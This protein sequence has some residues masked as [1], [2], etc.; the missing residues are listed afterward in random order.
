MF[1][2]ATTIPGQGSRA[3]CVL[4]RPRTAADRYFVRI[5]YGDGCSGTVRTSTLTQLEYLITGCIE[6]FVRSFRWATRREPTWL[7]HSPI[8][9][10]SLPASF[11]T[12]YCMYSVSSRTNNHRGKISPTTFRF[13]SWTITSRS[14][15]ICRGLSRKHPIRQGKCKFE[16]KYRDGH[17]LPLGRQLRQIHLGQRSLES[18]QSVRLS[19][20]HAL[21]CLCIQLQWATDYSTSAIGRFHWSTKTAQSHRCGRSAC[22]LSMLDG[23]SINLSISGTSFLFSFLFQINFISRATISAK[24]IADLNINTRTHPRRWP[25]IGTV[26]HLFDDIEEPESQGSHECSH[27]HLHQHR[28]LSNMFVSLS[29]LQVQHLLVCVE[30][31]HSSLSDGQH[32]S[33]FESLFHHRLNGSRW[34]RTVSPNNTDCCEMTLRLD[35]RWQ[36]LIRLMSTSSIRISP[37]KHER[38]T[39]LKRPCR[40]DDFPAPIR[41]M[42]PIFSLQPC[43]GQ[44]GGAVR[45]S[46]FFPP[47]SSSAGSWA[48]PYRRS[49]LII[50]CSTSASCRM[51]HCNHPAIH[52]SQNRYE[53]RWFAR[54]HRF[55]DAHKHSRVNIDVQWWQRRI[56]IS[57][58]EVAIGHDHSPVAFWK[59][60]RC[61]S[62]SGS[63]SVQFR[64]VAD[65]FH[66]HQN[67]TE[68]LDGDREA[69]TEWT[70]Y[71]IE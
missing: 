22:L 16:M 11:N 50:S 69:I 64:K 59:V 35:R 66:R 26:I 33:I 62:F 54:C 19:E 46:R 29:L 63:I 45:T 71:L 27:L 68:P 28:T 31:D 51:S 42:I 20:H 9:A 36:R 18:E 34:Y 14:W 21:R 3:P 15:F 57:P 4:F 44:V 41:P 58:R 23:T 48:Y 38:L 55:T 65:P 7:W 47:W 39:D 60:G 12:N 32:R 52:R 37:C 49:A 8:Q 17:F 24:E 56:P 70:P 43:M 67:L 6:F 53:Q 30:I 40:R 5:T 2:V 61:D 10:A 25:E 1:S 13:L